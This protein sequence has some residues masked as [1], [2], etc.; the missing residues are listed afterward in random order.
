MYRVVYVHVHVYMYALAYTVGND[1][2]SQK[3]PYFRGFLNTE[4]TL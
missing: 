3:C 1:G 2:T 4:V